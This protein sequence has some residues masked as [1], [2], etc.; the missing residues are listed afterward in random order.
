MRKTAAL[1]ILT[2]GAVWMLAQNAAIMPVPKHQFCDANGR[3]LAGG[4]IYT[5][6][7]GTSTPLATYTDATL[8]SENTNPVVLDSAGR[9]N[10]WLGPQAYKIV[11]QNALGVQQWSVDNVSDIGQILR[12]DLADPDYGG[13][14]VAFKSGGAGAVARTVHDKI[15]EEVSAADFGAK[16][17]GVTDD[18]AA[19]SAALAYATSV[20]KTLVLPSGVCLVSQGQFD[21]NFRVSGIRGAPT[22]IKLAS[23]TGSYL[24]RLYSDGTYWQYGTNRRNALDSVRLNGGAID[25]PFA[26][27]T[28]I[29]VGDS[30]VTDSNADFTISNIEIHGFEIAFKHGTDSYSYSV[31]KFLIRNGKVTYPATGPG[32]GHERVVWRDGRY[33]DGENAVFS[34]GSNDINFENVSFDNSTL[35]C[36]STAFSNIAVQGGHFEN[37]GSYSNGYRMVKLL[38]PNCAMR[39]TDSVLVLNP[40]AGGGVWQMAPFYVSDDIQTEQGGLEIDGLR[41]F[42][43]TYFQSEITD[44]Q[45]LL[46]GGKGRVVARNITSW[47][48]SYQWHGLSYATN[49]VRNY[50]FESG[51][52]SHWNYELGAACTVSVTSSVA[53]VGQYSLRVDCP[54]GAKTQLMQLFPVEARQMISHV[55]WVKVEQFGGGVVNMQLNFY[56]QFGR[57]VESPTAYYAMSGITDWT[58][59]SGGTWVPDGAQWG[60]I[61][62]Y[63][64]GDSAQTLAYVDDI[65]VSVF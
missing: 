61:V 26:G 37:P 29:V 35:S 52:L 55:E 45:R 62:L 53:K 54:Q 17:D 4:K 42:Q 57:A 20:G 44:L 21:V 41:T 18:Q 32:Y 48:G 64:Q 30:G 23:A 27:T 65:V 15:S 38:G 59:V 2:L 31:E 36:E 47:T 11:A 12:R 50:G 58:L 43:H 25:S 34:I 10:I 49:R 14:L 56:D 9:A 6:A 16:C 3:P 39:I 24:I 7:A 51:N 8:S 63:F 33:G 40:P 13:R 60:A 46:V 22:T 5:Y 19:I 28:A 1:L